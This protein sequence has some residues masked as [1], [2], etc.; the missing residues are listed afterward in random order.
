MLSVCFFPGQH[1][2]AR[3]NVALAITAIRYGASVANYTEVVRLLKETDSRGKEVVCGA[4]V[5]DRLTGKEWDIKAKC[6]VNAT[7][8]YI[9][10]IRCMSDKNSS[11]LCQPSSGVH[12]VLPDYYRS[13]L[14]R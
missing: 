7:G 1:D 10:Q 5:R 13:V 11:G 3:M 2:D 12:I 9:D 4:H 6:V 8:P 14:R